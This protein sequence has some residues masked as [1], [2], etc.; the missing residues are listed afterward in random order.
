MDNLL[1]QG[2]E[3]LNSL[4]DQRNVI[5]VMKKYNIIQ[6]HLP[7]YDSKSNHS[8]DNCALIFSRGFDEK[9]LMLQVFLDYRTPS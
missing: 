1:D 4:V 5:K 9:C 6:V 3:M 8:E 7:K 2:R